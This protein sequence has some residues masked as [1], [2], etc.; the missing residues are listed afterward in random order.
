MGCHALLQGIFAT[1]GLNLG[2]LHCRQ[3]LYH[4]VTREAQAGRL[5]E[6]NRLNPQC[7]HVGRMAGVLMCAEP[8]HSEAENV[9]LG[10]Q[11]PDP[12]DGGSEKGKR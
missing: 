8:F 3:V 12:G 7:P 1:Q 9:V 4:R 10:C 6:N 2:P 5:R 11:I